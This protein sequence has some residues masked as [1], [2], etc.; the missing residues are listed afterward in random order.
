MGFDPDAPLPGHYGV[1]GL[2]E[3][4]ELIGAELRIDSRRN[5]GTAVCV[6]LRLSPIAFKRTDESNT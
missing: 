2:R 4:A 6:S 5:E 1:V 3:Q